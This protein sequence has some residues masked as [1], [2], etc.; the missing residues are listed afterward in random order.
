MV[1]VVVATTFV[2]YVT[3]GSIGNDDEWKEVI[4]VSCNRAD[5]LDFVYLCCSVFPKKYLNK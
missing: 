5:T 4:D 1:V 2:R 3:A